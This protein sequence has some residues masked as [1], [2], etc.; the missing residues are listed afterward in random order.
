MSVSIPLSASATLP[1]LAVVIGVVAS[2]AGMR[3][4]ATVDPA[5][6]FGGR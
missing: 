5:A 1:A 4:T 2:I 3:R 6:A